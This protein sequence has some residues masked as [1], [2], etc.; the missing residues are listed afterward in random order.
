[1]ATPASRRTAFGVREVPPGKP[2]QTRGAAANVK[3]SYA[4]LNLRFGMYSCEI[5]V[6]ASQKCA[7]STFV[8]DA[9]FTLY[10]TA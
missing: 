3:L 10:A 7:R 9:V 2:S 6:D 5:R 8:N 4:Q 1:M